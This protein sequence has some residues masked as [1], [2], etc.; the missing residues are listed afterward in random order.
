MQADRTI[1]T[2]ASPSLRQSMTRSAIAV[3]ALLLGGCDAGGPQGEMSG[4]PGGKADDLEDEGDEEDPGDDESGDD[5]SGEDEIVEVD[6]EFIDALDVDV[7]KIQLDKDTDPPASY[8]K[9][10]GLDVSLGGTEFWQRWSGGH[11]PTFSFSDGTALGRKCMQASAIRFEAI[12]SDPPPSIIK[13]KTET[14]WGGSFFN[15]NDDFTESSSS[16]SAPRL[17]A[18]RTGLI[19]WISQTGAEGDCHL[20]TLEMVESLAKSC[21]EIAANRDGEI[22]GC[23]H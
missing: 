10:S 21:L 11:S 12:M 19:K 15:W 22:Q 17:W 14:N 7:A 18:W 16:A 5:E 6:P 8:D 9:P 1:S 20:P 13:L 2:D 4:S 23:R 3:F